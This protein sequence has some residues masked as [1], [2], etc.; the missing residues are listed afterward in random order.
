[1]KIGIIGSGFVGQ[2]FA[3]AL[4]GQGHNVMLSSREP[5]SE[6]MQNL[7]NELSIE[8]GT[9]S[10]TIGFSNIVAFALRWEAVADLLPQGNLQGKIVID[11]MNRFGDSSESVGEALQKLIPDAHVVKTLN[12]IG[13]EHYEAPSFDGQAATMFIAS[14]NTEAKTTVSEL[15]TKIGFEVADAGGIAASKH[16]EN[17][18]SFWVYLAFQTDLGR[19]IAFKLIEKSR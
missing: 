12:I 18:A 7:K 6:R 11:M 8:V 14:D 5:Q 10:E 4:I 3:K 19:N 15:L 13:A 2:S 1:M 16:L 9:I 17:L